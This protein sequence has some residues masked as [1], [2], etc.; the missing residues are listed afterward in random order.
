MSWVADYSVARPGGATLKAAGASGVVRY[1]GPYRNDGA[2]ITGDEYRDLV[3]HG[4]QVGLVMEY[5]AQYLM[6]GYAWCKQMA[7][8]SRQQEAAMG[9]PIGTTYG[10]SDWD[11]TLGGPPQSPQALD[12]CKRSLDG[13]H[14]MADGL[15]GWQ[16]VRPYGSKYFCEWVG[17][18]APVTASWSTQAWSNYV[19][20]TN[21]ALYQYAGWPAGVPFVS[22]C[23]YNAVRGNW[24]PRNG[25]TPGPSPDPGGDDIMAAWT[26][27]DLTKPLD[28]NHHMVHNYQAMLGARGA[29]IAPRQTDHGVFKGALGWFQQAAGLKVDYFI[30]PATR[31]ALR[32][33]KLL[34]E[35]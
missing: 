7:D 15:G 24:A 9:I 20:A 21:A 29:W 27:M 3:G 5:S 10:A 23:D 34:G 19:P 32:D 4:L 30:G 12:N 13:L 31:A 11:V 17:A 2:I 22:G 33:K 6:N 25:Q 1:I 14:G 18:N 16:Y 8:G 28:M 26:D 35:H